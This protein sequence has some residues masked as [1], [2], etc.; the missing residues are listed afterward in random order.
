MPGSLGHAQNRVGNRLGAG[1][2]HVRV[3]LTVLEQVLGGV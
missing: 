1:L 3:D 2:R